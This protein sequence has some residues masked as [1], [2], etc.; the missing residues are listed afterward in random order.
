M[1][2][3]KNAISHHEHLYLQFQTQ[4][5]RDEN[6]FF[7][8]FILTPDQVQSKKKQKS[9]ENLLVGCVGQSK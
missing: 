2:S 4:F 6:Q 9:D 7:A 8:F 3:S 5:S 1:I